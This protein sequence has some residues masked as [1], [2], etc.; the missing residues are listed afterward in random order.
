[1]VVSNDPVETGLVASLGRPGG[2]ITGLT[3]V[4]D[5]LAGKSIEL[6][7]DTA[8]WLS[9]VAVL[10]NPD[11]ADPEFRATERASQT[12]GVQL[13][14]LQVR[15]PGDFDIAFQ[16]AE[17]ERA[18]ALI[19]LPGRFLAVHRQQIGDFA[20]KNRLIMVGA[21]SFVTDIG[22][23]LSYGPNV[24]EL[25]RL[26]STYVDKILKGARPADLPMQQPTSFELI[27]NL[28]AAKSLGLTIPPTVMARAD[29]VI[30]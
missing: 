25:M 7:K 29:K 4:H 11:H 16:A 24:P 28:K 3:Y 23:L 5:Q 8:P 30:E 19:V 21:S 10:W 6:L 9:R 20:A 12:M 22:G 15:Q 17:R 26:A 27:V 2:N 14:S 1:V 18:E 13:Q